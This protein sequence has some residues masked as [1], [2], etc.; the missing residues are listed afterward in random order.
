MGVAV[1]EETAAAEE[2]TAEGE[3][4]FVEAVEEEK[5]PMMSLNFYFSCRDY[6]EGGCVGCRGI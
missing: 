2:G 1:G 3:E 6:S 4:D 5:V